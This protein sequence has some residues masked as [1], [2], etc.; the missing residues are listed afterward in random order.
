MLLMLCRYGIEISHPESKE[1]DR[2]QNVLVLDARRLEPFAFKAAGVT[3]IDRPMR[4]ETNVFLR[5]QVPY[6]FFLTAADDMN[7]ISDDV[8]M[9]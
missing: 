7:K 3:R 2:A 6:S 1:R 9:T 4:P 8:I 5:P